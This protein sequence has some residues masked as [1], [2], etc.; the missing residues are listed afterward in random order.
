MVPSQASRLR[1]RAPGRAVEISEKFSWRR[2]QSRNKRVKAGGT[3]A[4]P[5][6]LVS[7]LTEDRG[8]QPHQDLRY[9]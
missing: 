9:R 1:P 6:A 5:A 8:G 2:W 4:N 7:V 3:P